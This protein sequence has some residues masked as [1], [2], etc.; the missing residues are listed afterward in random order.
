MDIRK[1]IRKEPGVDVCSC[2][3]QLRPSNSTIAL[4][5]DWIAGIDTHSH[6]LGAQGDQ[7][8]ALMI[9]HVIHHY[10]IIYGHV[11]M[12]AAMTQ[13]GV[14]AGYKQ[15]ELSRPSLQLVITLTLLC[16][17]DQGVNQIQAESAGFVR[18]APPVE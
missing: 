1:F 5:D 6:K 10:L 9:H 3:L 7:V 16:K 15:H 4:V 17:P 11:F 18:N 12:S 2:L 14:P 13:I 8:R